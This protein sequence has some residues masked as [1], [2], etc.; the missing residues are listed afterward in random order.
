VAELAGPRLPASNP[1][2]STS[3][4]PI[5]FFAATAYAQET[6]K[7]L[8][9]ADVVRM[10]NAGLQESTIIAAIRTSPAA[11]D[12]SVDGLI[13]LKQAGVGPKII[14]AVQ[15]AATTGRYPAPGAPSSVFGTAVVTGAAPAE[16]RPSVVLVE[17]NS[18]QIMALER[19]QL[20]QTKTK[21]TS[22][23]SLAEDKVLNQTYQTGVSIATMDLMTH[24]A[25]PVGAIATSSASAIIGSVLFRP[26]NPSLTYVWAL[27]GPEA[28]TVA[29]SGTL[30]FEASIAGVPGVNPQEYAPAVVKLTPTPNQWRLVGATQ[31]KQDALSNPSVEWPIYSSFI[32]DRATAQSQNVSVGNWRIQA[33]GLAA[34]EYGV[35]F[36]PVSK[37]KRVAGQDVG[38]NRGDGLLFN[39]VWPFAV[40]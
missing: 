11:F 34:G 5:S 36:R 12:V 26:S 24:I 3:G 39:S 21:A 2:N 14:D 30:V 17:G 23:P 28:K 27:P 20:A 22:L 1:G 37:S 8:T 19:T 25:S 9:N 33:D 16:I 38:A 31:G 35:V 13:G 10:V 6:H 4:P 15:S 7:S 32:E 40:K 29:A 18:R